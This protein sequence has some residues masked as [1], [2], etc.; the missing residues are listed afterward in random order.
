VQHLDPDDL[1]LLAL[2][3]NLGDAVDAHVATCAACRNEI[4]SFKMTVGLAELSN[5]GEDAPQPGEH[6]WAAIAA[7]LG[8]AGTRSDAVTPSST[9][10][11]P[12][13]SATAQPVGS[14]PS[15]SAVS[16]TAPPVNG[17]AR[18]TS[19]AAAAPPPKPQDSSDTA[20][21]GAVRPDLRSVAGTGTDV[22]AVSGQVPSRRRWTRWAAPL[23]AAVVGIVIGAGA[24]VIAQNNS[25][26][27]TIEAVAPL[28][29]VPDGPL[30]PTDG[31][32][33]KAELVAAPTGQ[34]VR[35]NTADLP[36]ATNTSYEV[37]LFGDDGKMV[38]L[39][40]LDNGN[41]TF[42]VPQGINTREYRVVDVSDEPPDGNP[43]HSGISLIRGAFS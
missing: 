11:G 34:E 35:V 12:A 37:W 42:T 14:G 32:L 5:Y 4:E 10:T 8:F 24:V 3:E 27:V 20:A 6:V 25:D 40:T 22:P 2:G 23:A 28:T 30:P 29:P 26:N 38:S 1:A 15:S 41:G 36:P 31:Q 9:G 13:P 39:G 17:A 7:E 16:P 19:T 18:P 21:N 43:A 33:G